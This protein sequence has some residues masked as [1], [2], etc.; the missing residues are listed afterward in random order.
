MVMMGMTASAAA[1]PGVTATMA[2]ASHT[3][4]DVPTLGVMADLGLPDGATA[5]LV[6]R[7]IRALRV[8]LGVGDNGV[9]PG[10]RGGVTWIPFAS[11]ATPTLGVSYGRFFE[12]DANPLVR[13]ISGDATFSSPVLD[14]VGYDFAN[15]RLGLELG[16]K[17]V[18][19]FLHAGVSAVTAQIH[20][21]DMV[22]NTP[23]SMVTVTTTDPHVRLVSVSANL[24]FIVYLF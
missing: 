19:F 3:S 4:S 5:S 21:L 22:T 1:E 14:R 13:S 24:G 23:G 7:P 16:R 12:R 8:E 6:G 15:A 2:P 20:N 11:W 17:H 10:V 9:G 18:T